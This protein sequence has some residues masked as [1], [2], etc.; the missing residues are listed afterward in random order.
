[1][2][3]I[4]TFY[5]FILAA[6]LFLVIGIDLL[7]SS[8]LYLI[9]GEFKSYI[10]QYITNFYDEIYFFSQEVWQVKTGLIGFDRITNGLISLQ[11]SAGG[12]WMLFLPP[13]LI[14]CLG[15][16]NFLPKLDYDPNQGP[17]MW[18][19]ISVASILILG[20]LAAFTPLIVASFIASFLFIF[21]LVV[22]LLQVT[23]NGLK[24]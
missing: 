6:P 12:R 14:G 4:I 9:T 11:Y 2:R 24:Y 1:M 3:A 21:E 10:D 22:N 17:P 7:A 23:I 5:C 13:A 8:I 20:P 18:V 16:S 15:I 19:T